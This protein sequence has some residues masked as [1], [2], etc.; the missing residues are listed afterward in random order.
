MPWVTVDLPHIL[1]QIV[2]HSIRHP[3]TPHSCIILL[4]T[5]NLCIVFS[6]Q[7]ELTIFSC[8]HMIGN[9]HHQYPSSTPVTPV[10]PTTGKGLWGVMKTVSWPLPSYTLHQH[11]EGFENPVFLY[12]YLHKHNIVHQD[13]KPD[14]LVCDCNFNLKIINTKI[15]GYWGTKGWTVP[16]IGEHNCYVLVGTWWAQCAWFGATVGAKWVSVTLVRWDRGGFNSQARQRM[17]G[18]GFTRDKWIQGW[19]PHY[20]YYQI[21]HRCILGTIHFPLSY[22]KM[23]SHTGHVQISDYVTLERSCYIKWKGTCVF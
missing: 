10:T 9:A 3:P 22:D 1:L 8:W 11:P 18:I 15:K 4:L 13:I 16:E 17:S 21:C 5:D 12:T 6:H 23:V 7:S 14:N 2:A 20:S 19:G